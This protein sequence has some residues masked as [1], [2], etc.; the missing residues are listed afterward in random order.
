MHQTVT[1]SHA[2][3]AVEFSKLIMISQ[4]L[5]FYLDL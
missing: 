1:M 3:S 4:G 2:S 5:L